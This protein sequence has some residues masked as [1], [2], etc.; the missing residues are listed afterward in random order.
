[1]IHVIFLLPVISY[2][3]EPNFRL[4]RFQKILFPVSKVEYSVLILDFSAKF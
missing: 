4:T 3:L 1:M 2:L